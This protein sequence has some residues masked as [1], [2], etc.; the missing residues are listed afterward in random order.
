MLMGKSMASLLD[1]AGAFSDAFDLV[2]PALVNHHLRVAYIA[3]SLADELGLSPEERDRVT[4]AGLLHDMGALELKERLDTLHFDFQNPLRHAMM[5]YLLLADCDLLAEE[6]KAI[7]FHH[8][9]WGHGEGEEYGGEDVPSES[10][11]LHLADRVAVLIGS[12]EEVLGRV[13]SILGAIGE[14]RGSMFVPEFV[15]ALESLSERDSFWLDASSLKLKE[16]ILRYPLR[17]V[18][19]DLD[20]LLSIGRVFSRVIDFR[21]SF[22]ATHTAGVAATAEALAEV[23]GFS[24]NERILMR[25]AGYLHDLGKLAVPNSILEKP[26]RLTEE[27]FAVIRSHAYHTY[28]TLEGIPGVE[29]INVW[30]ALHHERLDGSGYPFRLSAED[31]PLGSRIMAVA[32][33]FTALTEDR[34][35]RRGMTAR[36]ALGIVKGMAS[37]GA[38]D[39]G[40]VNLLERNLGQIDS[41]R[42]EAQEG[43]S[44]EFEELR[45]EGDRLS[46]A[47]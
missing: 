22:T 13:D 17:T 25:L 42:R 23:A 40:I 20:A 31:L 44:R 41:I 19:L 45:R 39:P 15:E 37:E 6:A 9:P 16:I 11:L 4:V 33:V 36:E 2:D 27:E 8:L 3:R 28:R 18:E 43:A 1:I 46:R 34:P 10:H 29:L 5:G 12:G 32:D 26:G 7:R 24:P 21:S 38:L 30:G 14:R 47:R 35:Y